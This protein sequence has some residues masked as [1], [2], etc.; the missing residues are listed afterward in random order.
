MLFLPP[1][2]IE[3]APTLPLSAFSL[4]MK[5]SARKLMTLVERLK[6]DMELVVDVVVVVVVVAMVVVAT[7][8]VNG[9]APTTRPR[10]LLWELNALTMCG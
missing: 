6:Q 3:V 1:V 7:C 10:P 8:K 5:R 2:I 9:E 4:V